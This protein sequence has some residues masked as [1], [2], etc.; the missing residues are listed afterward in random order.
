MRVS[1]N[2]DHSKPIIILPTGILPF[3]PFAEW[4]LVRPISFRHALI[5]NGD[6]AGSRPVFRS[7]VTSSQQRRTHCLKVVATNGNP[8]QRCPPVSRFWRPTF[9]RAQTEIADALKFK[10][11]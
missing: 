4:I 9:D 1:H 5:D 7:E 3:E 11:C 10:K 2:A 6:E 8:T